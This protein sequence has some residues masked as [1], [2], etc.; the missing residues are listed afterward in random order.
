MP[1]A[2]ENQFCLS[3]AAVACLPSLTKL[4]LDSLSG[5]CQLKSSSLKVLRAQYNIESS[6]GDVLYEKPD[7]LPLLQVV[8]L[9]MVAANHPASTESC[10]AR[11]CRRLQARKVNHYVYK[12][13]F[14]LMFSQGVSRGSPVWAASMNYGNQL[15]STLWIDKEGR[16][17]NLSL[18]LTN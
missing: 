17:H 8:D 11:Y 1:S 5:L 14:G 16:F 15:D 12:S 4:K 2:P 6:S 13:T 7:D 9:Q 3:G 18:D 10:S